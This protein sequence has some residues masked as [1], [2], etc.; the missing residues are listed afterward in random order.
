MRGE[1]EVDV[2]PRQAEL[3]EVG[4]HRLGRD[5]PASRSGERRSR[6]R[7]ASTAS[8]PSSPEQRGRGGCTPAARAERAVQRARAAR[9]FGAVVGAADHVRDPEVDVVDDARELVRRR[10][11]VAQERRTAESKRASASGSPI[12]AA[13]RCRSCALALAHRPFVPA[14]PEPLE[15]VEDRLAPP[16]TFRAASVSSIRSSRRPGASRRSA[17]SRPR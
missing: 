15:V 9:S 10:A 1:V 12:G 7:R 8:R 6:R 11:V 2:V 14:D 16:S 5:S 13:S 3:L 4:A 17:G